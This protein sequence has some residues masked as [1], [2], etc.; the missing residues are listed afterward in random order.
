M[1]DFELTAPP[2]WTSELVDR[3]AHTGEDIRT[4]VRLAGEFGARLPLPGGG[5]TLSRWAVLAARRR[6]ST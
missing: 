5:D 6:G 4:A 1:L 3:A 2:D